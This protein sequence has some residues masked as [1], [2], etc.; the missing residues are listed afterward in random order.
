[1][2]DPRARGFTLIEVLIAL[3]L[4]AFGMLSLAR[5]IGHA[6]QEQLEGFQR[7]Q[8]MVLAQEMVDRI[9]GDQ[10]NALVYVGDYVPGVAVEDCST[11]P[12][13]AARNGCEWRNRLAGVDTR[14]GRRT[15]GAPMA[16]RGCIVNTAPNVYVVA[17]AWQGI[18][19]TAAPDAPCGSGAYDSESTRRVFSTVLQVATL[20]A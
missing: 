7:S 1:M 17:V 19:A 18:L 16:A 2:T 12:T 9:N 8:A 14:E 15:I 3:V 6:S 4:L 10:R 5:G 11:A 13:T 20:G